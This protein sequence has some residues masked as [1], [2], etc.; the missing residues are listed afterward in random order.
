MS[1]QTPEQKRASDPT[2]SVWVG[3]SAGT[4]KTFVLTNRVLR[5]MLTGTRPDKILCLTFTKAAAAEMANRINARLGKWVRQSDLASDLE[6]VLGRAPTPDE[7]LL[8]RRLFAEVLDVPGGL[9]IQT[10]HAFC[11]SLLGRFPIEANIPPHFQLIEERTALDHLKNARDAVLGEARAE[12][13]PALEKS[14]TLISQN[15]TE[16]TFAELMGELVKKRSGVERLM[17]RFQIIDRAVLALRRMLGIKPAESREEITGVLPTEGLATAVDALLSGTKTDVERGQ[18]ISGWLKGAQT[19]ENYEKAFLTGKDEVR[20]TLMTKKPAEN[21]PAA[22]DILEEEAERIFNA[23]ARLNLLSL[24]ENSEA[25]L[26][27]GAALI[28]A[29]GDSKKRHAVVDYDDLILKVSGLLGQGGIADW[30]M[31]K[32]DSGLDHILIDEAQD[33]NPEQWQ[34]VRTLADEFFTGLSAR[35]APRTIFAV[36]DVKQ[37]IYAFQRAEPAQFKENLDHFSQRANEVGRKFDSVPLHKSFRSS[38]VVLKFVDAVFDN[39]ESRTAFYMEE[40]VHHEAHRIGHAGR[41]ELW[42]TEKRLEDEEEEDWSPP[43]IQKPSRT[44]EMRLANRIADQIAGWLGR[45][46][47]LPSRDRAIIPGDILILVRRRKEFDDFMIRALKARNIPV[48]GRDRMKLSEQLAVMD[49][50]AV[51]NF[52]LLP[53]D[54]LTLAVVLKSP[55]VGFSEEDLYNLSAE[56]GK[57]SLWQCL[58]ARRSE[59]GIFESAANFLTRL[60]NMA[61]FAPPFE[62]Y[63]TLLGPLR[64]RQELLSRLGE[65]ANDP[66]DEFLAQAMAFEKNNIS[67]LQGFLGWIS[68]GDVE[69]VRDMEQGSNEVRIMTVHGA[70]GLQAPIVILPDCCQ[71]PTRGDKLL[72]A[73]GLLL[74]PGGTR[75]E[76]GPAALAREKINSTREEEYLRLFYVALTRAEDRLYIT[77]WEGKNKRLDK[78][79][80]NLA[81][82]T[83]EALE[84]VQELENG[85]RRYDQEQTAPVEK[86]EVQAEEATVLP[87]LP[88]WAGREPAPEPTPSRPLTP[89][90][91]D[92]DE[93]A[94]LSP[95][96]AVERLAK[97]QQRFHRGRLIH[98]LLEILPDIAPEKRRGAGEHFLSQKAHGLTAQDI[99]Q[100]IAEIFA[101][102]EDEKFAVLFGPNSQAEVPLVGMVGNTAL[103]GQVDRLAVVGND[104]WIVDYKTNRPP[105]DKA[106]D[107]PRIYVR[108]M[109]AYRAVL[110][111]IYPAK[112]IRCLLLWTDAAILM[113]LEDSMMDDIIF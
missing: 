83:F 57:K 74:W 33:T 60:T 12:A 95:L 16:L 19:Y 75:H 62:F 61:D 94:V 91:P 18:L 109:A 79:W 31:Y 7:I 73:D 5:L 105:P 111:E 51:G 34:V 14:L 65:E 26:T 80:Y 69:I 4:G 84:N 88:P 37:S 39:A 101:I 28:G 43:V 110:K 113:E 112:N 104:V 41:V 63:S 77:G 72:W 76:T 98:R 78:C 27:L 92:S 93:P 42:P 15:V 1:A 47:K 48:A 64:G 82:R 30:V 103:S 13:N 96:Q 59:G 35:D 87:T 55:F 40:K 10:I 90:R 21:F 67:S 108:Q 8:A 45:G 20:K 86:K 36:G 17:D 3:A 25:L 102:L 44:P 49:L 107:V 24:F 53:G 32:L 100:I 50:M 46:E 38:E 81:E 99:S 89:A 11:Q 2:S 23:R 52:V 66:I 22:L 56:R 97:D 68:T 71:V 106:K 29:Y 54:D 85:A 9:K 70:K 58:L 6:A